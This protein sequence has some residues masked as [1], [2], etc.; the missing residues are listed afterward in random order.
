MKVRELIEKLKTKDPE[1]EVIIQ[2]DLSGDFYTPL[3]NIWEGLLYETQ[4]Y[5][6]ELTPKAEEIGFTK[7]DLCPKPEYAVKAVFLTS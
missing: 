4:S 6:E 3:E 1:R 5:I 2:K 7:H